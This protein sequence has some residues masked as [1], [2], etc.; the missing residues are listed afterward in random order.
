M[1]RS[2]LVIWTV[3]VFCWALPWI[4]AAELPPG[5]KTFQR[6]DQL[7]GLE[8]RGPQGEKIGVIRD[9]IIDLTDGS[10]TFAALSVGGILGLGDKI[11]IVPWKALTASPQV[12]FLSLAADREKMAGEPK[13]SAEMTD[14]EYY[15][16]VYLFY[17]VT[18]SQRPAAGKPE[19]R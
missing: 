10:V 11:H 18:P 8:V 3:I 6:T 13:R 12:D 17:G 16:E 1:E 2:A 7:V 4:S 5:E 19:R 15:R 14:D 9:L